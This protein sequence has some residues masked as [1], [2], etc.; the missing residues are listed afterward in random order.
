MEPTFVAE[1]NAHLRRMNENEHYR[2]VGSSYLRSTG[3]KVPRGPI[4]LGFTL[5]CRTLDIDEVGEVET[6]HEEEMRWYVTIQQPQGGLVELVAIGT[7]D[8][9]GDKWGRLRDTW[10]ATIRLTGGYN[11]AELLWYDEHGDRVD[12]DPEIN[13][14]ALPLE[15]I[16]KTIT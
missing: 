8:Y 16:T 5:E 7:Y 14:V 1:L 11:G 13:G 4:N 6:Y 15:A 9:Y 10:E 2:V 3:H 12:G